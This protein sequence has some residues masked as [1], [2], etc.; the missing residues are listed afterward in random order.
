MRTSTSEETSSEAPSVSPEIRRRLLTGLLKSVSRAFYLSIRILPPVIR[1]PVGIS[2]LLARAAD[3]IADSASIDIERRIAYLCQ[4][5]QVVNNG[6]FAADVDELTRALADLRLVDS[7][8][9][10]LDSLPQIFALFNGLDASD[11]KRACMV[12]LTLTRGMLFDLTTFQIENSN[13]KSNKIVSL[14]T[15]EHLAEYCYLVAGCVGEF[16]TTVLMKHAPCLAHW[17]ERKMSALGVRFGLAL[18]MTNILR[19]VSK[20]LRIGRCYL[21]QSELD[22]V[23]LHS[24]DL[25]DVHNTLKARPLLVWGVRRTLAYFSSAEQYTLAI[26]RR[27][28]RLRIAALLPLIIGLQTLVLLPSSE[29]WLDPE[30]RIKI[31]RRSVYGI[32]ALSLLF[33]RSNT[34]TR[35]W[36]RRIRRK[37]ERS[38]CIH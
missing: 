7:E 23:S 5:R 15:P 24:E 2:Y 13:D 6:A 16:L 37:V 3:T 31:P 22:R 18:Q 32:I 8:R 33:G 9:E 4:F 28:L 29:D 12:V 10:L 1:E 36:I 17:D 20:D 30:T 11:A 21:P 19:D 25:L 27:S 34:L 26:P 14:Q 38:L 35:L